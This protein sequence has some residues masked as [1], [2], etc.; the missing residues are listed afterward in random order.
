MDYGRGINYDVH[1]PTVL[2]LSSSSSSPLSFLQL[3]TQCLCYSFTAHNVLSVSAQRLR[4]SRQRAAQEA[5]YD[6]DGAS[7]GVGWTVLLDGGNE[8]FTQRFTTWSGNIKNGISNIN[9]KMHGPVELAVLC[10]AG[11]R[12]CNNTITHLISGRM[13]GTWLN[14]NKNHNKGA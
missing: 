13:S 9:W 11:R 1:P 14:C 5:V 4:S 6:H 7:E 8:L 10:W 12:P 2:P 3:R